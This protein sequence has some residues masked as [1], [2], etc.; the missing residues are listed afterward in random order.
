MKL[1]SVMHIAFFTDRMD[2]MIDF[3]T[4]KLGGTVK[5]LTRYN[6]Y[7]GRTDRPVQAAIAESDPNRIVNVYIELAPG[8]FIELFPKEEGQAEHTAPW[9]SELGYSH[10]AVTV[11]DIHAAASDLEATGVTL[12]TSLSKG[13]SGT[14]QFWVHDPDGNKFEVMQ[15]TEDSYQLVGHIDEEIA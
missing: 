12:D 15:Y 2:E 10:F 9:N 14:W 11:D 3:Y 1:S 4:N 5:V 13:P 7:R 6:A 8:Q